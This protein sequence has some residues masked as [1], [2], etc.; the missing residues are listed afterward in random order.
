MPAKQKPRLGL[1]EMGNILP[2][3]P[4]KPALAGRILQVRPKPFL[5]GLARG[6]SALRLRPAA[7]IS[8]PDPSSNPVDGSGTGKTA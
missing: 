8:S 2:G 5:G 1:A 7:S 6:Y 3:E 4:T